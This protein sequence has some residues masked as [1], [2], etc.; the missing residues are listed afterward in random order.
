M[1]QQGF[2]RR[3]VSIGALAAGL[4]VALPIGALAQAREQTASVDTRTGRVRGM[5]VEGVSSFLGI[6]YGA[7]TH[8]RRFQPALPA[9]AW[10]GVRDC[11]TYGA[12][13]PQGSLGFGG[14]GAG[15]NPEVMRVMAT[16]F[17]AGPQ[18]RPPPESEDC[19][20]LNVFTPDASRLGKRPV[21]FWLH[22]GGFAL[23]SGSS[24]AYD[25]SA[26]CRRGDVVVVTINHRLTAM[27]YLYLG[28][29]DDDF[30]DSG[31]VGQLDQ[32]LALQWV[33]DNIE[34]FGG[35]PHNVTIFGE[36]GGGAKVSVLL[37]MPAA[38][39]LFQKA[40]IQSGP[41]IKMVERA[42]AAEL[43]ERTLAALSVPKA[44]PHKLQGLDSK[45]IISAATAAQGTPGMGSRSLSPVVDG[46]SLPRHPFDPDAP[47]GAHNI[48]VIIGTNKDEATL[49]TMFDPDFG[50]MTVEQVQQR[51]ASMLGERS[52]AAL[53][54]FRRRRP[55]DL[56]T[57]WFTSMVTSMGTWS[58]S[59]R[60]AERK[61]KQGGAP[62][63]MYRLD[64]ET[65]V[66]NG[67]LKAPHGLDTPL[68][69]DNADKA[70]GL[71]GTGPEPRKIADDMSQA[72]INF[73]RTGNPS[74]KGLAWPPYEAGARRTMIFD[75][76]SHVVSDPDHEVRQ[77]FAA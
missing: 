19:L 41:G 26:L 72:W 55:N 51:F 56:P 15:A 49:F 3:D 13:A 46:R 35:D 32:I 63:F 24:A 64:W 34:A 73:A 60:L 45:G 65:P 47:N 40:I 57:Y 37:A 6:P 29:L 71:C 52:S 70:A 67:T 10:T 27:G 62:A 54:L 22:G 42:D 58:N 36:S 28:A 59:I 4:A 12:T 14:T 68:V 33:R 1:A 66:L 44:D 21:M 53:E 43:A 18:D 20:V 17:S 39:G 76:P 7:D 48:P 11:F 30:A 25:G 50:K 31:N 5:R 16:L 77:F 69:F 23:G 74:A 9:P 8:S 75:V 2:T 61:A 38:A